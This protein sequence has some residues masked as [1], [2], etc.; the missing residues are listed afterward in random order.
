MLDHII[1]EIQST[2]DRPINIVKSI[3]DMKE[4]SPTEPKRTRVK[5]LKDDTDKIIEDK[6]FQ[7]Q[8]EDMKFTQEWNSYEKEKKKF[9]EEWAMTYTLI[10]GTFCTSE[11]RTAVKEH[12]EFENEIRD[13]P[14]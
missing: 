8:T 11:M 12:P 13:E 6:K 7:Q 9:L 3:R 14:L 1:V 4:K 10:Y 5:I 2:F